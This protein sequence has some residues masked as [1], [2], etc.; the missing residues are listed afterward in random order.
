MGESRLQVK[1]AAGTCEHLDSQLVGTSP[2]T[3]SLRPAFAKASAGLGV[4]PPKL[5]SSEGG[6]APSPQ[7]GEG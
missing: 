2:L 3:A 1:A 4:S 7:R 5:R 6:S